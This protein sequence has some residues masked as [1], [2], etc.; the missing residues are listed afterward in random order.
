[1]YNQKI[2]KLL[3]KSKL[4]KEPYAAIELVLYQ[5]QVHTVNL[6]IL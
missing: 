5:A 6:F 2:A 3:M 4:L 1:M